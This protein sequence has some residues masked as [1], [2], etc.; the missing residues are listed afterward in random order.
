MDNASILDE[1]KEFITPILE[2][3]GVELVDIS[4]NREGRRM[5]LRLLVDTASG[6]T[7]DECSELNRKIGEELDGSGLAL[8]NYIL[9][10]SSP[11]LDRPLVSRR[12]FERALGKELKVI[13]KRPIVGNDNVYVG[14][15]EFVGDD[16]ITLKQDTGEDIA[17]PYEDI[18][19]A[20][21]HIEF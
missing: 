15:L 8:E 7:I 1:I 13:T 10:V 11:G 4:Y 5:V 18:A 20:R 2:G 16:D 9:E 19:K 12:D 17:I 21:L 14:H 6:I 3:E